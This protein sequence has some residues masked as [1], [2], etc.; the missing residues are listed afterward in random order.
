MSTRINTT[1]L[2][3]PLAQPFDFAGTVY[4]HGWV[5]LAPNRWDAENGLLQRVERL[6]DGRVVLVDIRASGGVR[7]AVV[8]LEIRHRGPLG[9][10][11]R[12]ELGTRIRHMLRLDEDLAAFYRLCRERGGPW[13]RLRQGGGRLLRSPGLFEDLVKTLCTT[14]IQWSGTQ[15]MALALVEQ[16]GD[17]Y[18]GDPSRRAFPTPA[19]IAATPLAEFKARVN[20]GYRGDYV[21]LLARRITDGELDLAA[22]ADPCLTTGE[23][24]RQLLAIKGVGGYAAATLLML[25]GRYDQLP[26]DSVFRQFVSRTYFAGA[27]V[28][29]VA[30]AQIYAEWGEWRYLAY[31][32]ELWQDAA[33]NA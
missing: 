13:A 20:L 24:R 10:R 11:Q 32:H 8:E 4:S 25:L 26:V 30:A 29:D 14:N 33:E 31:W 28:E 6:D 21:H 22:L 7:R 17:S 3:L 18:P 1:R 2:Q 5:G 19:A 27:A 9:A 16:F 23:L 15:R 12:T